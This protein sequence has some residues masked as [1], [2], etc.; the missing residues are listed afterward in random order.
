MS[1]VASWTQALGPDILAQ[2]VCT[3]I[4]ADVRAVRF[5]CGWERDPSVLWVGPGEDILELLRTQNDLSG[6][7]FLA[8][9]NAD[10][11][12]ACAQSRSANL[13]VTSLELIRL[14]EAASAVLRRYQEWAVLLLKAAGARRGLQD[15]LDTAAHLAGG[16]L[17][18]LGADGRTAY[19]GVCPQM[20]ISLARRLLQSGCLPPDTL[21]LE[22]GEG[23]GGMARLPLEDGIC[24]VKPSQGADGSAAYMLLFTPSG[25]TLPDAAELLHLVWRTVEQLPLEEKGGYWSRTDL[26]QFLADLLAKRLTQE[27]EIGRQLSRLPVPA[28]RFCNFV[29]VE[30]AFP[31]ARSAVPAFLLPQLETVFPGST[32][33]LYGSGAVLLVSCP[34]R[35]F[36]P[37]PSFDQEHLQELLARYD[38]FAAVSNAT[39][40]RAMLRTT[41]LLTKSVM[42]L[43]QA[44]RFSSKTRIFLF[45]DYA[46][47]IAI[48]LCINSFVDLMGHDDIIYLAHPGMVKVYRY[49]AVR[50]TNLLDVVYY[51]CL[52]N[53]N[54]SQAAGAAYMHRNTFAARLS[55]VQE[56]IQDDLS[57][58]GIRQRMIFSYKILRYY[59]RYAKI[60][61]RQRLGVDLRPPDE[62]KG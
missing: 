62:R 24:W 52:N 54:V 61:L 27:D 15:I 5:V 40:R 60:N 6:S 25:W 3:P 32:G 8:A 10:G 1:Q 7:T 34:D 58:G 31:G 36:Q 49:D 11:L 33:A 55:K 18:L 39:S 43:G 42:Q 20:D 30:P 28:Q 35:G 59:D 19:S 21:P 41:Y 38:L 13:V 17:F 14:H 37:S 57:D 9:G 56:L 51:Y 53:C 29:I 47:Y 16:A 48:D 50:N 2:T 26:K 4:L 44:L 23:P 45:E 22:P 12:I 46:E